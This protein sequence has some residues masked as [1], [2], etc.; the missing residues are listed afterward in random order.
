MVSSTTQVKKKA[1]IILHLSGAGPMQIACGLGPASLGPLSFLFS[2]LL[3]TGP[4]SPCPSSLSNHWQRK[5]SPTK[6]PHHTVNLSDCSFLG[7]LTFWTPL[8]FW[9]KGYCPRRVIVWRGTRCCPGRLFKAE[10][11]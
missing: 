5:F 8:S 9:I 7:E 6:P 10:S 11:L 3:L 2:C 1:G 4:R